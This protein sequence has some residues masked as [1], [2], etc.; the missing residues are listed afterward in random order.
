[1]CGV[2]PRIQGKPS[3]GTGAVLQ[4]SKTV[5]VKI[6]TEMAVMADHFIRVWGQQV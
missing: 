5:D 6:R 3:R 1:M 4:T 2:P